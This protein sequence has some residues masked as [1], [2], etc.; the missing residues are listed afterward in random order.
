MLPRLWPAVLSLG[1]I[2]LAL[3]AVQVL[4]ALVALAAGDGLAT[5]FLVGA[6][7]SA[8]LGG[9]AVLAT[10]GRRF[11]LHFRDAVILTV[12]AWFVLPL[13]ATVPL[14]LDPLNL[15][16]V[17]ALFEMVSGIT[18]TGATVLAGLDTLPP[19]FL[20]W[21]STLQ[22]LGGFGIIGLALVVL[23]FLKIGG[24]QLFRLES[25]E[26]GE[27]VLPRIQAI[28]RAIGQL[29]LG[30]TFFCFVVYLVLGMTPFDALNHAMTTICTG[31]FSTHD[32]SF[33]Y[34]D[35]AS[36]RWAG[37][38][39]MI[40]G[41][42]PFIAYLRLV[43]RGSLRDRIDP[44]IPVFLV[45]IVAGS[46]VVAAALIVSD[47]YE[48]GT[49]I[50]EAAFNITSVI[51]TTGYATTDFLLWGEFVVVVFFLAFFVGGC[52]GSTSGGI[53]ILRYQII[54]GTIA[55]H[56]RQTIYPHIVQ[57]VRYGGKA[58]AT[59][60]IVSVGVFVFLYLAVFVVTAVL[61]AVSGLDFLT[62]LSAAASAVGNTGPGLGAEIGP[63]GMYAGFSD[64]QK[65]VYTFAMVLGRLEIISV[66]VL[67]A[68]SFY[69]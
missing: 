22:W 66:L 14:L 52:S 34:F 69:R 61:F 39:F 15:D 44:Q 45:V 57:P 33:G 30:L 50:T 58:I 60:Q 47:R 26:R 1:W 42:I 41:G 67:F 56:L 43:G 63:A 18:T 62:S 49:A 23:P 53:K 55:R 46:A 9:C 21:R 59:E 19:S 16:P 64:F 65:I 7:I 54:V 25:S 17:D 68:P 40:A 2:I 28:T 13:F 20:L 10:R 12:G 29:Y 8:F 6:S 27:K 37:T 24:M 38:I 31:G 11:E 36:I 32:A 4:M 48:A 51:T 5:S 3:A 35:S